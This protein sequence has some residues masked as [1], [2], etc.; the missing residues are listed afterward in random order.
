MKQEAEALKGGSVHLNTTLTGCA[1]FKMAVVSPGGGEMVPSIST[2]TSDLYVRWWSSFPDRRNVHRSIMKTGSDVP[3][4]QGVD[5]SVSLA[6]STRPA[7][8]GPLSGPNMI[9]SDLLSQH[10]PFYFQASWNINIIMN[11]VSLLI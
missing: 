8:W 11:Q 5:V 3:L 9:T 7:T 10:R 6:G 1:F 4:C 2:T